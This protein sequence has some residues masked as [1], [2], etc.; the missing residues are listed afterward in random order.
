[1]AVVMGAGPEIDSDARVLNTS[2]EPIPGLYAAGEVT[3]NVY[4]RYYVGTGYAIASTIGMGRVAGSEAAAF[5][6]R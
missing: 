6:R 1:M 5:A 3:G 2:G 4:G